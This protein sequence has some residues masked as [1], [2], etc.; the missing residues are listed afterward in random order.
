MRLG[1]L[2]PPIDPNLAP[3]VA[4]AD[5]ERRIEHLRRQLAVGCSSPLERRLVLNEMEDRIKRRSPAMVRVLECAKGLA[6]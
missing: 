4:D 5:N 1:T 6:A 2:L 3:T